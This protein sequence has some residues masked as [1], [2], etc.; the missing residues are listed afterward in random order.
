MLLRNQFGFPYVVFVKVIKKSKIS[1]CN[2]L[3]V[4]F[5]VSFSGMQNNKRTDA[6]CTDR[7]ND[8]R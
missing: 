8:Y 3:S 4:D 2:L 1:Q 6:I 5:R 7:I